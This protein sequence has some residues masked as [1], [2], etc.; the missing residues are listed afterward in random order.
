MKTKIHKWASLALILSAL[1]TLSVVASAA[2]GYTEV[3]TTEELIAALTGRA[4]KIRLTD[5]IYAIEGDTSHITVSHDLELD[6]NDHTWGGF[7]LLTAPGESGT[8]TVTISDGYL[9]FGDNDSEIIRHT[10]G[11]LTLTNIVMNGKLSLGAGTTTAIEGCTVTRTAPNPAGSYLNGD[12]SAI[13][14]L[15]N[16]DS[17]YARITSIKDS[18]IIGYNL[19]INMAFG[20][21]DSITGSYIEGMEGC[22]ILVTTYANQT[23]PS[24]IGTISNCHIVGGADAFAIKLQTGSADDEN[25]NRNEPVY[26][27]DS[28]CAVLRQ[29]DHS[30]QS[31]HTKWGR[32]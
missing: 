9:T 22:G 20:S 4:D 6:L 26:L 31:N 21:I 19:G 17:D 30:G 14:F 24:T 16:W 27:H 32:I 2:D 3:G 28:G 15:Q 5:D 23:S 29:C 10:S 12:Y 13:Q 7:T 8:P 25:A 11:S 1:V 18:T